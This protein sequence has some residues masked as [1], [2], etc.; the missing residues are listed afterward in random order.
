MG[1]A[2]SFFDKRY[3]RKTRRSGWFQLFVAIIIIIILIFYCYGVANGKSGIELW[4]PIIL[5][6]VLLLYKAFNG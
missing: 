6:V 3:S 2:G 5:I 1:R 4:W